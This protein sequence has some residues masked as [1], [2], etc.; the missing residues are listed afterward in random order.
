[1]RLAAI[2]SALAIVLCVAVFG[3]IFLQKASI[4]APASS[5]AT[6]Q[7]TPTEGRAPGSVV[8]AADN[9]AY[10][11]MAAPVAIAKGTPTPRAQAAALCSATSRSDRNIND[12]GLARWGRS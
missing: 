6:A 11:A 8:T 12:L 7:T 3:A 10:P 1:M 9:G 5:P 4:P 2:A